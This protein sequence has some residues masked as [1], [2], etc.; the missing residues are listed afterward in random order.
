MYEC[1]NGIFTFLRKHNWDNLVIWGFSCT[2]DPVTDEGFIISRDSSAV[3]QLFR[4]QQVV[5][6]NPILGSIHLGI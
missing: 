6:S 5:G 1:M 2:V 4:K 3:E